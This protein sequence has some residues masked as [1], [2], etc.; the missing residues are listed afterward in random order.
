MEKKVNVNNNNNIIYA[1]K[2]K[3]VS[4]CIGDFFDGIK[5]IPTRCWGLFG[6]FLKPLIIY[7]IIINI[8]PG[9][10]SAFK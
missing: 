1:K 10:K 9:T 2:E 4:I 5:K 6:I 3:V 8:L 7:I